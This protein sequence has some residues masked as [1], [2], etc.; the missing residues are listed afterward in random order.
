[1]AVVTA[2]VAG[3]DGLSGT[4]IGIDVV[5]VRTVS[6]SSAS[7]PSPGRKSCEC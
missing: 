6:S 3:I 7:G 5:V 4:I 1:V 2:V